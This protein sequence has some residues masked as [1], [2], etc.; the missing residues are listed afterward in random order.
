MT[1]T[2]FEKLREKLRER[3][4]LVGGTEQ[5]LIISS[6]LEILPKVKE[7]VEKDMIEKII[8]HINECSVSPHD[9]KSIEEFLAT[10]EENSKF[11]ILRYS[12][13]VSKIK[14]VKK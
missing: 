14:E 7:A 9:D 12:K 11:R 4:V 3:Y 1:Q 8:K 10:D 2:H 13:F 6:Q 5:G